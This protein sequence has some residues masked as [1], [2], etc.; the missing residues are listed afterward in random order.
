MENKKGFVRLF[1]N[2]C[3]C[4]EVVDVD[5]G[6][7]GRM[8]FLNMK[9]FDGSMTEDYKVALERQITRAVHP[10]DQAKAREMLGLLNLRHL[11]DIGRI[12]EN[13]LFRSYDQRN[14]V[15]YIEIQIRLYYS[16]KQRVALI[17]VKN[18]TAFQDK[19]EAMAREIQRRKSEDPDPEVNK[20]ELLYQMAKDIR[21]PIHNIIG[22][23]KIASI[24]ENSGK[25]H[26]CIDAVQ[27][28][29]LRVLSMVD[30]VADMS[31]LAEHQMI[32]H[33]V[34]FHLAEETQLIA[35][36]VAAKLQEK[37]LRLRVYVD[38]IRFEHLVGDVE[39]IRQVYTNILLNEIKDAYP[40]TIIKVMIRELDYYNS[41]NTV[42][43]LTFENKGKGM[44][45]ELLESMEYP[46]HRRPG[47]HN[48]GIS[49]EG[50]GIP[51]AKELVLLMDGHFLCE[52][53]P[54]VGT[55]ITVTLEREHR[56]ESA[57]KV[58]PELQHIKLLLLN[59]D[60][61]LARDAV[62]ILNKMGVSAETMDIQYLTNQPQDIR[63]KLLKPYDVIMFPREIVDES[64]IRYLRDQLGDKAPKL[65]LTAYDW[66]ALE[67]VEDMDAYLKKPFYASS[68][69]LALQQAMG[70]ISSEDRWEQP[71]W[72]KNTNILVVEDN[73]QNQEIL[74]ELLKNVGCNIRVAEN[75]FVA[76]EI[77]RHKPE[78]YFDL[79]IM[80]I[81]MP[82]MD[83]YE[84][85]Q[86][87]RK[88]P[89]EYTSTLPIVA[90][91][92][93]TS[94][95][96]KQKCVQ[97]GMDEHLNK[98]IEV[99]KLHQVLRKFLAHKCLQ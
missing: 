72:L 81:I 78:I 73:E 5:T 34:L 21:R 45:P 31:R 69:R 12:R 4:Y 92:A 18:L 26:E 27:Q 86:E 80:D 88:L 8:T 36:S 30:E 43:Q 67:T 41:Q 40:G 95:E 58:E 99:K 1:S 13:Y 49:G 7:Y 90:L 75:G 74:V 96:D 22:M 83:G 3:D 65:I 25:F 6:L 35:G 16:G 54:D 84:A 77:I 47:Q 15:V 23:C 42:I 85:T 2:Y 93:S 94:W 32:L 9:M 79:V 61:L 91:S 63:L 76:R 48:W 51:L 70:L 44:D 55:R 10:M 56:G 11:F 89:M 39:R 20:E 17:T 97:C 98:P 33:P 52:S 19:N 62:E 37:D 53:T 38:N 46:F 87:I 29:S 60:E 50:Y 28:E 66:D 24:N 64:D 82:L 71:L 57:Y 59:N 14:S 68:L